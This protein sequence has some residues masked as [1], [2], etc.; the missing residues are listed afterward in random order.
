MIG[1]DT[2]TA[3]VVWTVAVCATFVGLLYLLRHVLVILAF[4][5]VFAYLVAPLVR[6][7][8]AWRPLRERR[9]LAIAVVYVVLLAG[10]TIGVLAVGPRLT[11]E[12]ALLSGRLPE[13]SKRIESGEIVSG[14]LRERGWATPQVLEVERLI[15]DHAREVVAYAQ[16]AVAGMLK[17]LTGA[18]VIVLIPVFGFFF[19][20]DGERFAAAVEAMIESRRGRGLWREI[21]YDLHQLL[22]QY[23]R[24]LVLLCL[25]TFVAWTVVFLVAG[26]PYVVLL[27]AVGGTLE[28]IPVVGPLVAAVLVMTV[29]L[30]AGY[31]HPWLLLG[32]LVLWRL[33]QDY[34]T[35]PIVMSGG[36]ELHP[37][38]VIF[39]VIA[40][41]EI[42]GPTGMLLSVPVIA[43]LRIVWQ[44]IR[45]WPRG[46]ERAEVTDVRR[47]AAIE[48]L[49]TASG[50]TVRPIR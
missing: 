44:R 41:G 9:A 48:P 2:R 10:V 45:G 27:A 12:A 33:I 20:K 19:L 28:F 26:V 8:Q 23:V 42:A 46:P 35:S 43:G 49:P 40:G 11:S 31:P 5:L 30:F 16:Q 24:A 6:V 32:F 39:G 22:G 15:R 7:A 13:A 34:G 18:W 50:T 17:W 47:G 25:I 38:L 37:A 29:T 3:R 1:I 4:G 21:A 36:L 14:V